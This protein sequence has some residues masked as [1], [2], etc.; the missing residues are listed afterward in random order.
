MEEDLTGKVFGNFTV[1][2]INRRHSRGNSWLCRCICGKEL[3]LATVYIV[4]NKT[5]RPNKS[6]GC[7]EY[8][9]DG[10][11]Q[12]HF[13]IYSIWHNLVGRC[14]KS[15]RKN[16]ERFGGKGVYVCDEWKDDFIPF[17]NWSLENG[18]SEELTLM[19][20]DIKKPYEPDNCKWSDD[21]SKAQNKGILRNNKTGKTGVGKRKDGTF[22]AYIQRNYKNR[23]LGVFNTLEEAI[24]ARERAEEEFKRN[25][26]L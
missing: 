10:K 4:G 13:R 23:R 14:Y 1:V 21:C 11:V 8:K 26:T 22:I 17:L 16:Y 6:C 18:Y 2:G 9:Y 12:E 25:G 19:R 3:V 20:V 7:T 24:T 15:E 5:R